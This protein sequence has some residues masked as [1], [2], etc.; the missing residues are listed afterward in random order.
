[1]TRS[2]WHQVVGDCKTEAS[3]K[4]VP[5]DSYMAEDLLL[6]AKNEPHTR[7][8]AIG[9]LPVPTMKGKQP[10]WPD[11]LMKRSHPACGTE[12]TGTNKQVRLAHLPP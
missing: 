8:P 2:I 7:C 3:A 10:Y 4:P 9:F 6:L 11:N 12:A 1:M 5:L